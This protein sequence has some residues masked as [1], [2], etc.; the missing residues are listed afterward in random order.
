MAPNTRAETERMANSVAIATVSENSTASEV[1]TLLGHH[2]DICGKIL[3]NESMDRLTKVRETMLLQEL[4][5]AYFKRAMKL[6][7]V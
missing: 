5:K 6:G 1:M 3:A 7:I 2:M 4:I